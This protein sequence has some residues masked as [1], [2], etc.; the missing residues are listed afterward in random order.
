MIELIVARPLNAAD[1][2]LVSYYK[3]VLSTG[4]YLETDCLDAKVAEFYEAGVVNE[5][6]DLL[7]E[8]DLNITRSI[9][10]IRE[11]QTRQGDWS[12]T[13]I[14][15]GTKNNNRVFG[16]IFEVEQSIIGSGQFAPDFN[17]N[18]KAECMVFVDG[19]Q[20]M[21]GFL[22]VIQINI[23]DTDL[24]EYEC[25]IFG[26]TANFFSTIE[27]VKLNE[28][29]FSTY[30]HTLNIEN[31]MAS[32]DT[33]IYKDGATATFAYGDGYVYPQ[34]YPS[35]SGSMNLISDEDNYPALYAKSVIDKIFAN[36]GY[37]YTA[38]SFFNTDRF[39]RL[40]IPWPNQGLEMDEATLLNYLFQAQQNAGGGGATYTL[41]NQLLFGNEISDPGND[42]N[43]TTSTYTVDR[44][45]FY[46]FYHKLV[47]TIAIPGGGI[48]G[49]I[50]Q[51]S[52]GVGVY[53]NGTR[54]GTITHQDRGLAAPNIWDI[55]STND[56]SIQV[57][58]GDQVQLKFDSVTTLEDLGAVLQSYN[59]T[60]VSLNSTDDSLFYNGLDGQ[61]FAHGSGVDFSQFFGQQKQSELFLGICNLFNLYVEEDYLRTNTLR[62]VPRDDFYNGDNVNWSGKLDYS[63]TYSLVPMGEVVGNPYI[64]T[65]KEGGDVEN[66]RFQQIY[67][68][69][70]GNRVV[71]VE[72][73]FVKETKLIETCFVPTQFTKV[74][75]RYLS[76]IEYENT[77]S[78]ELRLLYYGGLESC[79][80]Y[81]LRNEGSSLTQY[82]KTQ[83]PVTLHIDSVS[84]MQFDLSFGMP[85]ELAI[86]AGFGY[87]N[88]NVGNV[89]WYR[90]LTEVADK[91][92]KV[93]KGYFRITPKDW[94]AL[95]FQDNYFFEGQ[96]WRLLKVNDYN[97]LT[98][99]VYECEFLL[100]KY[101]EPV[102]ITKKGVGQAGD[103]ADTYDNRYP[104]VGKKPIGKTG[105][106]VIGDNNQN[107]D[108]VIVVGNDNQVNG[109]KN[110]VLGSN[111]IYVA[112]LLQNVTVVGSQDFTPTESDTLYYGNY[113]VWP[114]FTAAGNV[115]NID[116]TD[117]PYSATAEDWMIVADT[118]T[119]SVSVVLPDPTGL[120]GRHF[121]IKKISSSNGVTITAGDGSVLLEGATSHTNNANNGFDWFVCDGTQYWLI[122]EGH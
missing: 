83:Y 24:I 63:Q 81:F 23:V 96:Y 84:D 104:V 73:D 99:G 95:K 98:D 31:V 109:T 69:V 50:Q 88:Q 94:A 79:N 10:D 41:G 72:N 11:P 75:D 59:Q 21:K 93:F 100:A 77:N 25:A 102:V 54:Y 38:D 4:G 118:T 40:I 48:G 17:P 14:L 34:T 9:A 27:N 56:F 113:K 12:K 51:V 29:D 28:L 26:T 85:Q 52:I 49:T 15:P 8:F 18:L 89:Y 119:A 65:Y 107:D 32:W 64:L 13:I 76:H 105:G 61:A 111:D 60:S 45:G 36:S 16:H 62:I 67:G 117:S 3:R 66:Q 116:N 7:N 115:V 112:P 122:S 46:T 42:Y 30:N 101:V 114:T 55:N 121:V 68:N 97:P 82:P 71:R 70:Y 92:S 110:V 53:I 120:K 5:K 47:G 108:E 20:Q 6:L 80:T 43:P 1:D 86:G 90:F 57:R 37:S 58:T 78:S 87:S 2:L 91:N 33:Y 44:G 103:T 19:M 35:K 39:K 74:T 106:V 22:R